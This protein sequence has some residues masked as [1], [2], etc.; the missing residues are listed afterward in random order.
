MVVAEGLA[1]KTE[2]M[3]MLMVS[4]LR[5]FEVAPHLCCCLKR[6]LRRD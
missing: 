6:R 2:R 3:K 5:K 4:T 1:L